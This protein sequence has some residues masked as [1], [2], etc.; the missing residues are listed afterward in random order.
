MKT[1]W[2][3]QEFAYDG[4]QLRSLFAYLGHGV[5]GDSVVAWSG[6]CRISFDHMVDGED[7]REQAEIRGSRMLHLIFELFDR[8]LFAGVAVQRLTASIAKDLIEERAKDV[9]LKREG[10]DLY[11][12][13]KKLSI[14]I[15]TRS[16]VSTLVHFAMNLAN[17]GTPV[18][19]CALEEDFGLSAKDF[20]AELLRRLAA[21]YESVLAAT[22]KVRPVP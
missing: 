12:N 4:T 13:G 1:L 21:E 19:T 10:D 11:W 14:S 7:L 15:A 6:A 5:L 17:A 20:A 9:R 8:D 2:L 16:P 22:R 18:P 3:D